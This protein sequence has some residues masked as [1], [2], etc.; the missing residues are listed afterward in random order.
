MFVQ[1]EAVDIV[2]QW[3]DYEPAKTN[4]FG[5]LYLLKDEFFLP[6]FNPLVSIFLFSLLM[7]QRC[8]SFSG[9]GWRGTEGYQSRNLTSRKCNRPRNLLLMIQST[10]TELPAAE[11]RLF[12]LCSTDSKKGLSSLVLE[13]RLGRGSRCTLAQYLSKPSASS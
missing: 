5:N 2:M 8:S 9:R 1:I 7:K 4:L 3:D 12:L 6:N 10:Q 11:L 13:L